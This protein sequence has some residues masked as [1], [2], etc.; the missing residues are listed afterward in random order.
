MER[1]CILIAAR[2]PSLKELVPKVPRLRL[3]S[4]RNKKATSKEDVSLKV[5]G[6]GSLFFFRCS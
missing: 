2:I 5:A 3:G 6:L 1:A 4:R